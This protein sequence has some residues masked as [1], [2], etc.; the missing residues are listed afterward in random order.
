MTDTTKGDGNVRP[1]EDVG[2]EQDVV[3]T[4]TGGFLLLAVFGQ[5][6]QVRGSCRSDPRCQHLL[7]V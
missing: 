7:G 4:S 3:V 2:G 6:A 1:D 5:A